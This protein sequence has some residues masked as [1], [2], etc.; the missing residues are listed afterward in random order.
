MSAPSRE[1]GDIIRHRRASLIATGVV[2]F[3]LGA[4][5]ITVAA[6]RIIAPDAAGIIHTC[7]NQTNGNWRVVTSW[8]DCR[9]DEQGLDLNQRGVAGPK[10]DT[11]T[12][13]AAGTRGDTGA[14]GPAGAAGATGASGAAGANGT[15][16]ATG[17][18]GPSGDTGSA[19]ASGTAGASGAT[20]AAGATGPTGPIGATGATGAGGTGGTGAS[21]ASGPSGVN[22]PPSVASPASTN[23]NPTSN[24]STNLGVLCAD[25]GG[26]AALTYTWSSAGPGAVTF[27]VNGTN[28]AKNTT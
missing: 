3:V 9:N 8:A 28:A 11:G 18:Q 20:G 12:N 17:P 6:S 4:A 27:S 15:I 7:Y 23:P 19:G 25:D 10:G 2:C 5:T 13:G 24:G 1:G 21:G 16:G 22:A 14:N 26:E